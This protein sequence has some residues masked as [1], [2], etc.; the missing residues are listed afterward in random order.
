M[1]LQ[2]VNGKEIALI[3]PG[4]LARIIGELTNPTIQQPSILLFIGQKAK[5][6]AL[7]ELFPNQTK[8]GRHDGIATLRIDNTSLYSNYPVLFADS[9]PSTIIVSTLDISCHETESF[10]LRWTNAITVHDIYN[11]LHARIFCPFSD[12]LCIFADDFPDLSSILDRLRDVGL[13]LEEE[14]APLGQVL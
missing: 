6:Q 3:N 4:R 9:Y 1:D 11:I 8:K 5:T 13:L 14:R 12:V 2:V 10:P 7:G